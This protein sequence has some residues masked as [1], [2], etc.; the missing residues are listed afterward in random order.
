M[1]ISEVLQEMATDAAIYADIRRVHLA[2][3]GPGPDVVRAVDRP[4]RVGALAKVVHNAI[5]FSRP[6]GHAL[7]ASTAT[8]HS[9][10]IEMHDECGGVALQDAAY[11]FDA[12]EHRAREGVG[13]GLGLPIARECVEAI[14]GHVRIRD[15]PDVGC[16]LSFDFER[17]AS[18]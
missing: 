9:V 14:G 11:L 18:T 16:V 1:T 5:T 8:R 6:E 2:V 7:L 10:T 4:L 15:V 13:P 12:R 17:A 3:V